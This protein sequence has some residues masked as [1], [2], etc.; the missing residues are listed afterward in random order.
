[1][2]DYCRHLGI[3]DHRKNV[4]RVGRGENVLRSVCNGCRHVDLRTND[5]S[6][7]N[8][9]SCAIQ[10]RMGAV[11]KCRCAGQAVEEADKNQSERMSWSRIERA[12]PASWEMSG[13]TVRRTLEPCRERAWDDF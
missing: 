11:V 12:F 4:E 10:F 8:M 6:V 3:F 2:R 7:A 5:R 9:S 13:Y 1:M